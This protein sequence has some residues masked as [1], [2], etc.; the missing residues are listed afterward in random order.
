M[1]GYKKALGCGEKTYQKKQ[2]IF[3]VILE[4]MEISH[5]HTLQRVMNN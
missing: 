2:M 5:A 4:S 1:D 3:T